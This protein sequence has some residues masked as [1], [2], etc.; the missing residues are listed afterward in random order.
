MIKGIIMR[1]KSVKLT[2]LLILLL[3]AQ[4]LIGIFLPQVPSEYSISQAGYGWWLDNAIQNRFGFLTS[5]FSALGFFNIFHSLWFFVTVFLL[6]CNILVCT[7]S[8]ANGLKE[9]MGTVHIN[10][11]PDFYMKGRQ[12]DEIATTRSLKSASQAMDALLHKHHYHFVKKE[13]PEEGNP[14]SVF[15][16]GAKNRFSALGTYAT[17][18]SLMLFIVG[19]LVGSLFGFRN[20]SFLVT[21]NT[22]R[23]VGYG[24]DLSLSLR[25]FTDEYWANGTPKDYR[26]EVTV[27]EKGS[28]VKS[29]LVRVNHPLVYRGIRFHQSAYGQAITLKITESNGNILYD[30]PVALSGSDTTGSIQRPAGKADLDRNGYS[31]VVIAP[32]AKGND[33]VFSK[34]QIGL[35]FYDKNK[36][37][38]K[39]VILDQDKPQTMETLTFTYTG[40]SQYSVFQVSKEP[41]NLFLWIASLLFIIGLLLSFYLPHRKI[42]IAISSNHHDGTTMRIRLDGKKEFGL[43]D[44]LAALVSAYQEH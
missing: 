40:D 35:E 12:Q 22:T 1:L 36:S 34:S 41:G 32:V 26:S 31:V 11:D 17:H 13:N 8:R 37:L 27:L 15:Y 21:E 16:A 18:V 4:S 3:S 14:E 43:S 5:I 33:P 39:G 10:A 9:E 28:K 6:L 2:V 25:S 19:I 23:T 24:T 7:L 44:E 30:S 38:I 20:N 29:G 42:W